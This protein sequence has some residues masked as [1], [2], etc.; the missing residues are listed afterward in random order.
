[1]IL[2]DDTI[3][4]IATPSGHG[5][6]G[7]IRLSGA[8]VPDILVKLAKQIDLK[9]IQRAQLVQLQDPATKD[10]L[11]EAIA[12]YFQNPKSYT[13]QDVAEISCHGSP[14]ILSRV[15]QTCF[16]LGARP[17][18]PGEFTMRAFIN[19]RID[20]TQAEAV[21][22]LIHAQT[23]YQARQAR[24]QLQGELSRY[25]QPLKVD[26]L[27]IIVHLESAVEFVEENLDTASIQVLGQRIAH[28]VSQLSRLAHS[29]QFGRV[30]R[31][32]IKL[33]IV[34]R[35][36]VGKSSLFNALLQQDR[37]IVTDIPGTTRDSLREQ[38]SLGGIPVH[39]IDTAGI[40]AATN[41]VEKMGIERS[42]SA[43]ADADLIIQV[44]DGAH[45]LT[46]EDLSLLDYCRNNPVPFALIIN[47]ADL[48]LKINPSELVAELATIPIFVVSAQTHQGLEELQ[49]RLI[50]H[51]F[52]HDIDSPTDLLITDARHFTLITETCTQLQEAVARMREGFSEEVA[53]CHL[54]LALK[55]LGEITGETTIEDIL[56]EI[57]AT[58]CIGK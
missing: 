48:P 45:E 23:E 30:V 40:H 43:M 20:L 33:A 54:H 16:Q 44:V 29:Y 36:N 25:L 31:E 1:M 13:G 52:S 56:G 28:L 12:V 38:A 39:L 37:A 49:H 42:Y 41:I 26:L 15:L 3:A 4:A 2:F 9:A 5:G 14:F 8:S 53:L 6:I 11:D 46:S 17:A 18:M 50:G 32:G 19:G 7:V 21:R 58:F 51:F 55:N 57:F 22:D 24:R 34:G 27:Q 35:P 47:K 10:F